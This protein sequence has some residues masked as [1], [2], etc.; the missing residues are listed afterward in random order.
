LTDITA[1][2]ARYAR[3]LTLFYDHAMSRFRRALTGSTYFFTLVAYRR[4]PILCDD[5]ILRALRDAILAVCSR[6][7]FTIDAWV[8]LPDHLHCIWTLPPDDHDFGRRWSEI[9]HRVSYNCR[10]LY[11]DA[12]VSRTMT[13]QRVAAIWQRRFWEHQIRDERDFA[14]HL[15]YVHI[16]AVKHG[17]ATHAALWP[18]SSFARYVRE[19]IYPADWCGPVGGVDLRWE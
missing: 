2:H 19:G 10:H 14:A 5:A 4:R 6:R 3:A 15:D 13:R 17:H 11:D 12:P 16:N 18:H 7:P 1:L 8:Q 9:K